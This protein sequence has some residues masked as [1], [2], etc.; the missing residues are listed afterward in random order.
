MEVSLE[1][2]KALKDR[3]RQ[4][5]KK[6]ALKNKERQSRKRRYATLIKKYRKEIEKCLGQSNIDLVGLK[7]MFKKVQKVLDKAAQKGVIHKNR[8]AKQKSKYSHKINNLE[9]QINLGNSASA[10]Q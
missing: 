9:K 5:N 7:K 10:E 4:L 6:E 2:K 1:K 8:A 3:K